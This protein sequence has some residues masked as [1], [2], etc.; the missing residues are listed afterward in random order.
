[1]TGPGPAPPPATAATVAAI[2][3]LLLTEAAP[4]RLVVL[5]MLTLP[6]LLPS[7]LAEDPCFLWCVEGAG[8]RGGCIKTASGLHSGC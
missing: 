4:L 8:L 7:E 5:L 1:M 2:L 6:A 3:E